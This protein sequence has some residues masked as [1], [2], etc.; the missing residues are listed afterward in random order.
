MSRAKL[1]KLYLIRTVELN[2]QSK[3][4]EMFNGFKAAFD[5][6]KEKGW[7]W[8]QDRS[9]FGGYFCD[10]EGNCWAIDLG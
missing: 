8:K 4:V 3:V 2:G 7:T 10:K 1:G 6:G 9:I 5:Y